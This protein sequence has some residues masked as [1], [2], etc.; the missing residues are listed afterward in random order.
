LAGQQEPLRPE[1][2]DFSDPLL[3]VPIRPVGNPLPLVS[4][5]VGPVV[6]DREIFDCLRRPCFVRPLL[7]AWAKPSSPDWDCLSEKPWG[8]LLWDELREWA[9]IQIRFRS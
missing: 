5:I 7:G 3:T 8:S 2:T 1:G 6:E 9:T 4:A